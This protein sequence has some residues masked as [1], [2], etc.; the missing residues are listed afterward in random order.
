[1]INN[2]FFTLLIFLFGWSSPIHQPVV[3]QQANISFYT[4]SI[5]INYTSEI[6]IPSVKKLEEEEIVQFYKQLERTPYLSVLTAFRTSQ[7][8]YALSDWLLYELVKK[9]MGDIYKNKGRTY[10]VLATWFFM[11]KLNYN[12]RLAFLGKSAYLYVKT[13]DNIYETPMIEDEGNRFLGL[14]ELQ[15]KRTNRSKAV[16]LL[17]FLA[18]PRGKS[19]SLAF[20]LPQLRPSIQK[21]DFV[22][23]WREKEYKVSA[24]VDKT[25][26]AI[27]K[28]Y[29]IIDE[30][31]YIIAPFSKYLE[32]SLLSQL[33][34]IIAG[35]PL[36]QQV[37][38][39]T[40]FT[41]SAFNYK[42]DESYFGRSKPM[43]REEVFH[44]PYSDCED[45]SAVL[46]GLI[47]ELL[48]LPML[49]VAFSD[50]LTIAVAFKERIGAPIKHKG[51]TYY[52]CDPTGPNNSSDIGYAPKGYERQSFEILLAN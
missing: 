20:T 6:I 30:T 27:M 41:R 49:V 28:H 42:E 51:K 9:T 32:R 18:A 36:K 23:Q 12:T 8:Q 19:F 44:Y 48:N 3:L 14:T 17:N 16:Y 29:P 10:Q 46:Y 43:I 2:S 24:E 31:G 33:K 5:N 21:K 26:V 22:F 13:K 39:L 1:M 15:Y 34:K 38:I 40:S 47:E 7:K 4:E 25:L 37:E 50:H 11:S 45:R 52:I 35:K